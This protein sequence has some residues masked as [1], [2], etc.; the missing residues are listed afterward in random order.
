M[1]PHLTV[2]VNIRPADDLI[3]L[4]VGEVVTEVSHD[5]S[6]LS[7]GDQTVSVRVEFL[8]AAKTSPRRADHPSCHKQATSACRRALIRGLSTASVALRAARI[9]KQQAALLPSLTRKASS[10]SSSWAR[11]GD[12][13]NGR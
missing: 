1:E 4:L 2:T 9:A 8:R 3:Q 13:E 7:S 12:D 10:I 5:A 11:Q 6:Q